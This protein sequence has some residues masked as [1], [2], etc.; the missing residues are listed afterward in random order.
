[1]KRDGCSTPHRK[2]RAAMT[3]KQRV[4][5]KWPKA[6]LWRWQEIEFYGVESNNLDQRTL[7]QGT[8]PRAAWIDAARNL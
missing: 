7:G 1:M 4:L 5:K 2:A 3:P 8:S 6:Y